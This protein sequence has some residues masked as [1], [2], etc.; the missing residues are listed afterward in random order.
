[1]QDDDIGSRASAAL[2]APD[3]V[4]HTHKGT[5]ELRLRP[6]ALEAWGSGVPKPWL[7]RCPIRAY[8]FP[9]AGISTTSCED[10]SCARYK[11]NKH[12]L[13]MQ[14]TAQPHAGCMTSL[15]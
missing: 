8:R 3:L 4:L 9:L 13:Q 10:H 2:R 12:N 14:T 1:M 11:N 7:Q 5:L 15:P 6:G